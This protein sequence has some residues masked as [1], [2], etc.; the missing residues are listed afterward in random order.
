MAR[1]AEPV[2]AGDPSAVTSPASDPV[3][4]QPPATAA[5]PVDHGD[6]LVPAA[7]PAP[8]VQGRRRRLRRAP[9]RADPEGDGPR[10]RPGPEARQPL[11]ADGPVRR[12]PS[13]FARAGP[14]P[15]GHAAPVV[16]HAP[17]RRRAAGAAAGLDGSQ[18]PRL[19][20]ADQPE[21]RPQPGRE[22][23]A[24]RP[25]GRADARDRARPPD[26]RR[27]DGGEDPDRQPLRA[28]DQV[29]DRARAGR[30]RR[31]HLRGPRLSSADARRRPPDRA[32][33]PPARPSATT[34][35]TTAAGRPTSRSPSRRRPSARSTADPTIRS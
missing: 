30:G 1:R 11:P 12:H 21:R 32:S 19:H 13:G 28:P 31:R 4:A 18:L 3:G 9:Q 29:P 20:P 23:A 24:G 14:L 16:L 7:R 2:A 5:A 26:R 35:S 15:V 34:A 10:Q 17:D 27:G 33:P 25:G 22:D 8:R 6:R